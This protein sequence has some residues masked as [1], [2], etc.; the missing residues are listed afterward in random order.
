MKTKLF[1]LLLFLSFINASAQNYQTFRSDRS[2]FFEKTGGEYYEQNDIFPVVV[3]SVEAKNGDSILYL[4][5]NFQPDVNGKIHPESPSWLGKK[6]VVKQNG[7]NFLFN[8]FNDTIQINTRAGIGDEWLMYSR[9]DSFKVYCQV[10]SIDTSSFN[11]LK[12]SVKFI[13]LKTVNKSQ[14]ILHSENLWSLRLSKNY[15]ILQL[16]Y[17]YWFPDYGFHTPEIKFYY[18]S[19]LYRL[20]GL[21]TPFIGLHDFG[22]RETFDYQ[23]GDEIHWEHISSS[24]DDSLSIIQ[25]FLQR[26]EY[27]DSL[28][29]LVDQHKWGYSEKWINNERFFIK[30]DVH[31]TLWLKIAVVGNK[32][33]TYTFNG[34]DTTYINMGPIQY[35][36]KRAS[37]PYFTY[38][39][40][41]SYNRLTRFELSI[42]DTILLKK[43]IPEHEEY[44][45]KQSDSTWKMTERPSGF[46]DVF[47]Y[48]KG[49]GFARYWYGDMRGYYIDHPVYCKKSNGFTWGIPLIYKHDHINAIKDD[50]L[51]LIDIYPNPTS[52]NIQIV[53]SSN[54]LPFYFKLYDTSGRLLIKKEV[55]QLR[56]V[57]DLQ[58]VNSG[59]YI[60]RLE[61]QTQILQTG[62]LIIQ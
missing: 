3:D 10:K 8:Q 12:D 42:S 37:E 19:K 11:G 25:K 43:I 49:V 2:V 14:T 13:I 6:I 1:Y 29:Y 59:V 9:G 17:F 18:Y 4:Q 16:I 57:I 50:V 38:P 58:N 30:V 33:Q 54:K 28:I 62:K 5:N 55:T 46:D 24:K 31:D 34:K 61:N 60:Y 48:I 47:M 22:W 15:G 36:D 27:N 51:H 41:I 26:K 40:A 52:G 20:K 21:S 53:S 7:V 23:V 39:N 45:W 44:Y 32:Y 35:L 56:F